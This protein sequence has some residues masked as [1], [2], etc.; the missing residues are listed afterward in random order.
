MASW[1]I[2]L[3]AVILVGAIAAGLS[4]KGCE[5]SAASGIETVEIKGQKFFLELVADNASRMQGLGGRQFIADDGGMLFAFASPARLNF[6][7]RDCFVDIDVIFLDQFG[8]VTAVHHMPVEEPQ[9]DG[10][11]DFAYEQRLT[12]YPSRLQAQFAIELKGGKAAELGVQPGER[13]EL[14]V[15]RLKSLAK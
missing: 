5:D 13:I 1:R 11:S 9:R 7:M 10:E 8:N 6:V 14:D 12:R 15:E 4:L 2:I 3:G